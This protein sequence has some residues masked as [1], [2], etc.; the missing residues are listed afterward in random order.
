MGL[1]G[2]SDVDRVAVEL[3]VDGDAGDAEL[4]ESP[5]DADR[6]LAAVGYEDLREHAQP[7][8]NP[9]VTSRNGGRESVAPAGTLWLTG[10]PSAGK[11]TLARAVEQTLTLLRHPVVVVDGD[12]LRSGLSS[13]L[14]F[15]EEDRAEQARRAAHLAALISRAGVVAVVALVSPYAADRRRA[16]QI[17]DELGLP[18][19]EVW[20]DTP[21]DVCE[22][23]DTKGLYARVRAGEMKDLTGVDA[24]YEQPVAPALR[25]SGTGGDPAAA[26]ER[27]VRLLLD[28]RSA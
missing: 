14:G 12:E 27:A 3:R 6:D 17:H 15:S 13:D 9:R 18:F 2:A 24:P 26:A 25:V 23:R 21:P 16:R 1:I 19:F 20:V 7:P 8:Y 22:H 4:G 10:R 11:T 28:G 5:G